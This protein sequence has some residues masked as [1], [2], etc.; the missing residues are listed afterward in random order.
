MAS[1]SEDDSKRKGRRD[2]SPDPPNIPIAIIERGS[3]PDQRVLVSTLA[4]VYTA[5]GSAASAWD[6][7]GGLGCPCFAWSWRR[8]CIGRRGRK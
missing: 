3:M 4:H 5:P 2:G 6:D 8:S 1:I 7:D